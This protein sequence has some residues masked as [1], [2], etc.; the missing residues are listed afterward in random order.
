MF[1]QDSDSST[2]DFQITAHKAAAYLSGKSNWPKMCVHEPM[3]KFQTITA[4]I[5]ALFEQYIFH[6]RMEL[7]Y[8]AISLIFFFNFWRVLVY[9]QGKKEKATTNQTHD[10]SR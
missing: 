2:W 6:V 10:L 8:P 7:T 3:L 5:H 9:W 1:S 4:N